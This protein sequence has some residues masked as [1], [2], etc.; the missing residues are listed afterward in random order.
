MLQ[1]IVIESCRHLLRPVVRFL[2]RQGVLWKDFAEVAKETYVEIA[3]AEYGIEGRPTN[4]SR[5]S[6]LTG[7]SRREVGRVRD[8]LLDVVPH[9][10]DRKG[11]RIAKIL[12][13]WHTDSEFTTTSGE[14]KTLSAAGFE[15]L[16]KSYAG[17]LPHTAV[18]KEMLQHDLIEELSDGAVRVLQRDYIYSSLD[19]EIIRQM[20]IALHDHATTLDHNLNDQ[21]GGE[22]RFE[23][24]ADNVRIPDGAVDDF[25]SY[26][27]E[28]GLEFLKDV[29]AWLTAH[30]T[31][32]RDAATV[33]L[34]AGAYLIHND[35]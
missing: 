6:M 14:P 3:R 30:E 26:V 16:L 31:E 24:L 34:G 2:L 29:D 19:P 32:D 12:T 4:N 9:E 28:R 8:V 13:A 25:R 21:R 17:D 22:P 27:E 11:N 18:R 33:R 10:H 15:V 1:D 20:G 5:V 35:H 7:L 23:G